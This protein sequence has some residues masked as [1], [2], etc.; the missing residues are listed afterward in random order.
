MA[1]QAK[2]LNLGS[3][4]SATNNAIAVS[5]PVGTTIILCV[6]YGL[7]D[8]LS[9]VTDTQGN[10]YTVNVESGGTRGCSITKGD[11]KK[12]LVFGTDTIKILTVGGNA[13]E[14]VAQLHTQIN[15]VGADRTASNTAVTHTG[16][17]TTGTTGTL[18]QAGE[19]VVTC[20]CSN[21]SNTYTIPAAYSEETCTSTLLDTAFV[22]K[23]ATSAVNPSW[24]NGTSAS[25]AVA[26]A[27]YKMNQGAMFLAMF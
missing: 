27:T 17:L 7:S 23:V 1:F 19:L 3:T 26:V 15:A 16:A 10:T 6:T 22:Y 25:V 9:A 5:A 11:I 20:E 2:I 18:S 8:T 12:A 13:F 21:I 4:A 14:C 24:S